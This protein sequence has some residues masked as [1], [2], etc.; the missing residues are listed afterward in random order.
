[1][2]DRD[3]E[4]SKSFGPTKPAP[5]FADVDFRTPIPSSHTLSA[6]PPSAREHVKYLSKSTT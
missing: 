4:K 1:M 6:R 5:N 3:L 2:F